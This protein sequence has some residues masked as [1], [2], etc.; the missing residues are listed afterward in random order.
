MKKTVLIILVLLY[1]CHSKLS[2]DSIKQLMKIQIRSNSEGLIINPEGPLN[3]LRGYLYVKSGLMHNQRF[4]S[5]NIMTNYLFKKS[6]D[7]T[8][9][10]EIYKLDR[11]Y[12]KDKA[13]KSASNS[14]LDKY[15]AMYYK[16]LI[17]MFPSVSAHLSIE[18]GRNDAITKFLRAEHVRPQASY[19]L[20]SLL[21]LS[22]RIEIP[23]KIEKKK[24]INYIQIMDMDRKKSLVNVSM[25][26]ETIDLETKKPVI[27]YQKETA[28]ILNLFIKYRS[29]IPPRLISEPTTEEK[30]KTGEFLESLPFLIQTYIF[31]FIDTI[32]EASQFINA[33]Y[34]LL[35]NYKQSPKT[36]KSGKNLANNL[37]KQCFIPAKD[38]SD[39]YLSIVKDTEDVLNKYTVLPF[40]DTSQLAGFRRIP[41]YIKNT[42]ELVGVESEYFSNCV[43]A[44]LL[45]MFFCFTY[46]PVNK[47]HS[48]DHIDGLSSD[49]E[50]FFSN[51]YKTLEAISID[52]HKEWNTVMAGLNDQE[53]NR[54]SY[55]KKNN[56]ITSGLLNILCVISRITDNTEKNLEVLD[57]YAEQILSE[58]TLDEEFF[59][60][61]AEYVQTM[62]R[63]LSKN[64]NVVVD[65]SLHRSKRTDGVFD[66]FGILT[67]K[68]TL[69]DKSSELCIKIE[70][71]HAAVSIIPCSTIQKEACV[72]LARL[73]S[74]WHNKQQNN[75][76]FM[77]H[78]CLYYIDIA[79][80]RQEVSINSEKMYQIAT[81]LLENGLSNLN[82]LIMS[83]RI[84]LAAHKIKLMAIC[85][86]CIDS[87]NIPADHIMVRFISNIISS[88]PL[89]DDTIQEQVLGNILLSKMHK[90]HFPNIEI[91]TDRYIEAAMYRI[92]KSLILEILLNLN[93]PQLMIRHL[94][95]Q[96]DL[97][98]ENNISTHPLKMKSINRKIFRCLFQTNSMVYVD[99]LMHYIEDTKIEYFL[100]LGKDLEIIWLVY[101]CEEKSNYT[102]LIIDIYNTV[103]ITEKSSS[104]KNHIETMDDYKTAKQVLLD[105]KERLVEL[106]G[107]ENK[108]NE[109]ILFLSPKR[110]YMGIAHRISGYIKLFS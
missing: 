70:K 65:C 85:L 72:E 98:M 43:E 96:V 26:I 9:Y 52:V 81:V 51:H 8:E 27:N 76:T 93:L 84:E 32:E 10:D 17:M 95:I 2:L 66:I 15:I 3:I 12:N 97:H 31:E 42:T 38:E 59:D 46:C 35:N 33:V 101:A 47:I 90:R 73:K 30:F 69:G 45:S 18:T 16:R 91:S 23:I 37:F 94:I 49:L 11:H 106:P 92:E 89:E 5:P 67:V 57:R 22:E 54:I 79:I 13:H 19:I 24:N 36:S 28:E 75:S 109:I 6:D 14:S 62:F 102:D 29:L 78:L 82:R 86:A 58:D 80:Q 7:S 34:T 39:Q 20:A 61:V 21:L 40:Y 63:K 64:K 53:Y 77:D 60:S 110:P 4:F 44:M 74:A 25:D 83:K 99:Q 71:G 50:K 88:L 68:Y 1:S 103:Y 48:I 108:F 87:K 100:E 55:K 104:I 56:E 41:I 105:I 107:G